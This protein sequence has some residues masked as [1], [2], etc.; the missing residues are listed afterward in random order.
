MFPS[1]KSELQSL[2]DNTQV[3]IYL[4]HEMI[5]QGTVKGAKVYIQDNGYLV[6]SKY[7]DAGCI[8]FTVV[9]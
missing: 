8:L 9:V 4:D 3:Q 7:C 2:K 6:K 1:L 5:F